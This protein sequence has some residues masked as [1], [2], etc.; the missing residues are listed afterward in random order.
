MSTSK[1]TT[2]EVQALLQRAAVFEDS[3]EIS[4]LLRNKADE[5]DEYAYIGAEAAEHIDGLWRYAL[6]L[7]KAL[8]GLTSEPSVPAS[9]QEYYGNE[10]RLSFDQIEREIMEGEHTASSVFTRMRTAAL[11]TKKM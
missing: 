11:H 5:S 10:L 9:E 2:V 7:S 4:E 6:E 1:L 8:R 3:D